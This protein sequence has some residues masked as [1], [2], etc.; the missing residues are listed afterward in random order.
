MPR[1]TLED[2]INRVVTWVRHMAEFSWVPGAPR[3]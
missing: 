2:N 3:R 1:V